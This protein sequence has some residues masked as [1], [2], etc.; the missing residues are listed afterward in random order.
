MQLCIFFSVA[1]L[2]ASSRF[3]ERGCETEARESIGEK[4]QSRLRRFRFRKSVKLCKRIKLLG[5]LALITDPV[6]LVN[7]PRSH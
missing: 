1:I 4:I 3:N 5:R 6:R 2:L 7:P